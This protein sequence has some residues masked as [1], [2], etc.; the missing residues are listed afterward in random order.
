M[1]VCV[2][3]CVCVCMC[4]CVHVHVHVC[5]CACMYMYIHVHVHV[6]LLACVHDYY[7]WRPFNLYKII[8]EQEF[9]VTSRNNN[10]CTYNVHVHVIRAWE[11]GNLRVT[12][13]MCIFCTVHVCT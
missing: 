12:I 7:K 11:Q 9:K 5:V 8:S 10:Y 6:L 4:V 13:H 2:C 1:C 3:V